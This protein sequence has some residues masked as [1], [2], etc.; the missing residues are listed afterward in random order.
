MFSYSRVVTPE[1]EQTPALCDWSFASGTPDCCST[2]KIQLYRAER[3]MDVQNEV[4]L[5][6]KAGPSVAL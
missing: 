4:T 2:S 1:L 5:A 6:A 3:G